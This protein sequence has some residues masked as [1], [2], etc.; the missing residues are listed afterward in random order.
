MIPATVTAFEVWS[1][2]PG[3]VLC[4]KVLGLQVMSPDP[5]DVSKLLHRS[6]S[7][8]RVYSRLGAAKLGIALLKSLLYCL[9][10]PVRS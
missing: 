1:G 6:G 5:H 10:R 3:K 2:S 9:E 7:S 8:L 4:S